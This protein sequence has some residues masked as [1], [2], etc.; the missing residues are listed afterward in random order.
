MLSTVWAIV[1]EGRIELTEPVNLP[2]G[3]RVL[4]TIL[5]DEDASFWQQASQ[6]ALDAV[7]GSP[8]DDG[9]AS[10]D[11]GSESRLESDPRF[12]KRIEAARRS[13]KAGRGVRLEEVGE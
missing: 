9:Y 11:D 8:E 4:V 5:S 12:L 13:L 6:S 7:W 1:R 10:E 2:D 3:S